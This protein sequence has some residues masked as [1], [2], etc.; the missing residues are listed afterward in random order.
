MCINIC[1][2]V[3]KCKWKKKTQIYFMCVTIITMG[4]CHSLGL[5]L[6][7]SV[8]GMLSCQTPMPASLFRTIPSCWCSKIEECQGRAVWRL[9][10]T[11]KQTYGSVFV[12][13][14]VFCVLSG[15]TLE[16]KFM[17][18]ELLWPEAISI[19]SDVVKVKGEDTPG[20]L[21]GT[22][23][24]GMLTI[25]NRG[26]VSPGRACSSQHDETYGA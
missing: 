11:S 9:L 25:S 10:A 21:R 23:C 5:Q 24:G 8:A 16:L 26:C 19:T 3:H 18:I 1:I 12:S 2:Y 17:G 14:M 15:E 6:T 13:W 4:S 22:G 7:M 20:F